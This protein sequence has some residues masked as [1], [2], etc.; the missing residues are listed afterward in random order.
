MAVVFPEEE[1]D[2]ARVIE[3]NPAGRKIL[4]LF[5]QISLVSWG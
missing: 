4:G 2:R 3:M 1:F 5:S